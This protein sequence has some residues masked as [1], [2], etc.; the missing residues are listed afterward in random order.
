MSV[1]ESESNFNNLENLS[2]SELLQ[3]IN[4]EDQSVAHSVKK[5][6]PQIEKAVLA[7]VNKMKAGGRL[8]YIG[9]GRL[10]PESVRWYKWKIRN[11]RCF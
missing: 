10:S 6:L 8:F 1:T 5:A 3:G 11:I 7:I 9:A 4:Q 2:I